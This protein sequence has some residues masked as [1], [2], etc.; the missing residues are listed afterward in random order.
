V[1][2]NQPTRGA[3]LTDEEEQEQKFLA[4]K[5]KEEE[6]KERA[7]EKAVGTPA[8]SFSITNSGTDDLD[9]YQLAVGPDG[10]IVQRYMGRVKPRG[11][12]A[13][14]SPINALRFKAPDP[15]AANPA[16][17]IHGFPA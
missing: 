2:T 17:V 8:T 11:V 13:I 3:G 16:Q 4:E 9:L 12:L 5:L 6:A 7:D 15:A 14:D 10:M 1:G